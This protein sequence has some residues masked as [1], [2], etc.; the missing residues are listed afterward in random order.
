[1]TVEAIFTI[2]YERCDI[3][4]RLAALR[5]HAIEIVVDVR[6]L[7]LSRKPGFSKKALTD[8]LARNGVRYVHLRALGTAKPIR[9]RYRAE[10]DWEQFRSAYLL[11]L[12]SQAAGWMSLAPWLQAQDARCSASRPILMRAIVA[13]SPQR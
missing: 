6:D 4:R 12:G 13:W 5:A 3:E 10:R 8:H 1:V 9:A 2:G 11:H 7:P